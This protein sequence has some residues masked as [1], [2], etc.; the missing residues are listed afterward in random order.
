VRLPRRDLDLGQDRLPLGVVILRIDRPADL[1]SGTGRTGLLTCTGL[2][3]STP[4]PRST[5]RRARV[6]MGSRR[7]SLAA[8]AGVGAVAVVL[9]TP[10][11]ALA[12]S[13]YGVTVSGRHVESGDT[14]TVTVTL[15]DDGGIDPGARMCLF[16]IVGDKAPRPRPTSGYY[17]DYAIP[18]GSR[19]VK[20]ANCQRPAP[21]DGWSGL[22]SPDSG[23]TKYR[24]KVTSSG[25]LAFVAFREENG[26]RVDT[27]GP[28]LSNVVHVRRPSGARP[29]A[30]AAEVTLL[31]MDPAHEPEVIPT[32][33]PAEAPGQTGPSPDL[34]TP[35]EAPTAFTYDPS[36]EEVDQSSEEAAE[37][38][39][40]RE[41]RPR[42]LWL[43]ATATG[44]TLLGGLITGVALTLRSR[45]RARKP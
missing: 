34:G 38:Q 10:S 17:N 30:A 16:Q 43:A 9:A 28:A 26:T 13:D 6:V 3:F 25:W 42:L 15:G 21:D 20:V 36:S 7:R 14:V 33:P 32:S 44:G 1:V 4:T 31:S 45:A 19:Y 37:E 40:A 11:P 41:A 24:L 2:A 12:K 27:G 35:S 39:A 23:T 5:R 22:G 8:L 29:R 18:A